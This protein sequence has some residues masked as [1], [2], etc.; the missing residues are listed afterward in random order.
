MVA[1]LSSDRMKGT[2][3]DPLPF[4]ARKAPSPDLCFLMFVA[5]ARTA[6][7]MDELL[8]FVPF[9]QQRVLKECQQQWNPQQAAASK[10]DWKSR[11]PSMSGESIEHLTG[12]PY[13]RELKHLYEIASKVMRVMDVKITAAN[14]AELKVATQNTL[15][16]NAY[17]KWEDFP[18]STAEVEMLGEGD[19]W[20]MRSYND[21]NVHYKEPQ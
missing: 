2:E 21:N 18:Y 8:P 4:D 12:A 16:T 6:R 10:A 7:T 15:S 3:F 9:A 17:G 13:T 14:K 5:T 20:R 19:Y 1:P 11:N